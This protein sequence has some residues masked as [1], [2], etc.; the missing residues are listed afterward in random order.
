MNDQPENTPAPDDDSATGTPWT[1][2]QML[3]ILRS[4]LENPNKADEVLATLEKRA[5]ERR[6][7]S[8]DPEDNWSTEDEVIG[9]LY[10]QAEKDFTSDFDVEA[11]LR[12]LRRRLGLQVDQDVPLRPS[13]DDIKDSSRQTG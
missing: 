10:R 2:Q 1:R 5:Q 7:S 12:E 6:H 11:G 13:R 3:N 4:A 9:F 8:N